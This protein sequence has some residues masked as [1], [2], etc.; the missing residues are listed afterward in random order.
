MINLATPDATLFD[1]S[2]HCFRGELE[3]CTVLGLDFVVTHPGNATDGNAASGLARNADA[4]DRALDEVPGSVMVLFETTAGSGSSL[5][6]T[7]EQ[8]AQLI[9]RISLPNRARV[10]VCVDTC[11]IWAAGYDLVTS[12]DEVF[13]R[14][15]D[16]IGLERL[17]AFHCNDS[18]GGLGSRRD[19]HAHIGEGLIGRDAFRR[20][21]CDER[22]HRVP[23]FIETPKDDDVL[24]ADRRNLGRLRR[25]RAAD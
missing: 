25:Y 15:D 7:F 13:R 16:L 22:F 1:R 19:R 6:A 14:F 12:Y 18:K 4:V 10:G 2:Y 9:E 11:H 3:R 23:K 20:L 17:R 24:K 5:G 21:M 8:M